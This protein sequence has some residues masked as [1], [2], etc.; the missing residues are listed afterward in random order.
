M[1]NDTG[2]R[3]LTPSRETGA[4]AFGTN[5]E[6]QE[7]INYLPHDCRQAGCGDWIPVQGP[8][9]SGPERVM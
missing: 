1:P 3:A 9:R 7:T 5:P 6:Q 8:D 2:C 4:S